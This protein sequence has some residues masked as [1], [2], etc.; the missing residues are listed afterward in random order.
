M[1]FQ[2]ILQ[3]A[4]ILPQLQHLKITQG[5]SKR[6]PRDDKTMTWPQNKREWKHKKCVCL[7]VFVQIFSHINYN[8]LLKAKPTH[9]RT[10][11]PHVLFMHNWMRD[12]PTKNRKKKRNIKNTC[13][14]RGK[15][16]QGCLTASHLIWT[17]VNEGATYY[18]VSR[19][20]FSYT[21]HMHIVKPLCCWHWRWHCLLWMWMTTLTLT[22][23]PS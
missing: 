6:C 16:R 22:F 12:I 1:I 3:T 2:L 15:V 23:P 10:Q 11:E 7:R 13:V 5:I 21:Y 20:F 14:R 4:N 9:T 18:T 19:V 17:Q 8:V